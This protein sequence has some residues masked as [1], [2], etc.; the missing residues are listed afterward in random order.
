MADPIGDLKKKYIKILEKSQNKSKKT[1]KSLKSDI[2]NLKSQINQRGGDIDPSEAQALKELMVCIQQ[3]LPAFQTSGMAA[4]TDG[5][6]YGYSRYGMRRGYGG[7]R[8]GRGRGR[9]MMNSRR[10]M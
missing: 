4:I 2:S 1:I 7:G 6:S 8:R 3:S 9:R 10:Y 5:S